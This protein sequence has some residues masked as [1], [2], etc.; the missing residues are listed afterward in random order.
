M[1]AD[2]TCQKTLEAFFGHTSFRPNQEAIVKDLLEG[3]DVLA[4]MATGGGKSLC[5]QL[6]AVLL[7][8]TTIVISP[9]IALMKD[10]VDDLQAQGIAAA[11]LTSNQTYDARKAIE[12]E[13]QKQSITILY[14][15]PE[16]L[17]L[18]AFQG[19][20]RTINPKLF[21]IDEAHCISQWG[22]Q[23]RKDYRT[24]SI[25]RDLFPETPIIALTATATKEVREDIIGQLQLRKPNQYVGGFD[26]E[27]IRYTVIMEKSEDERFRRLALFIAN[28]PRQS[29]II[30]CRSRKAADDI[31]AKLR[32][33]HILAQPYH[34]GLPGNERSR[35]QD[36][37]LKN[38]VP[39]IA[40]TIAFGMGIDKPDVRFVVHFHPP[41]DIESFYQESGRAGR[42][43]KP[44]ESLLFYSSQD[45]AISKKLIEK[46]YQSQ[47]D[48]S[49]RINKLNTMQSWCESTTCRRQK[50]LKVFGE[51]NAESFCGNCDIC[52]SAPKLLHDRIIS[53][54]ASIS[55]RFGI[56]TAAAILTGSSQPDAHTLLP[57]YGLASQWSEDEVKQSIH[58]LIRDKKLLLSGN[59]RVK[60]APKTKRR[61]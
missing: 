8:G 52:A 37:F 9:L 16:R 42:D 12:A 50:I 41:K 48:L 27:N 61:G 38:Q 4:V 15:S 40:A 59:M 25:I 5:Y 51:K 45:F 17:G 30:Y 7:G 11:L 24:L 36:A 31:A 39:V 54:I 19:L 44:A 14:V 35:V 49:I 3:R 43:G 26:R 2:A 34:A 33:R 23:F 21:A 20:L 58:A 53:G 29:G 1:K 57:A 56:D 46:E 47:I 32:K 18:P 60:A 22:H 13:L 28:H 6:P 10:Q 55:G